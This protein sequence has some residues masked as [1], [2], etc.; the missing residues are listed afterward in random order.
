MLY[1]NVYLYICFYLVIIYQQS[2]LPE[3]QQFLSRSLGPGVIICT[4]VARMGSRG[5]SGPPTGGPNAAFPWN[6]PFSCGCCCCFHHCHCHRS[7]PRSGPATLGS[8]G[9][10]GCPRY[11]CA[12]GATRPIALC[13]H[14]LSCHICHQAS[15]S[16]MIH[17][18]IGFHL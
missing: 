3:G 6:P 7:G 14:C 5:T 8:S 4:D 11:V 15:I 9:A 10:P 1:G 2:L 17:E 16:C 18:P 13:S 12:W